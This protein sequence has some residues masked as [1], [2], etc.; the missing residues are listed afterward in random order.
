M[1][2]RIPKFGKLFFLASLTIICLKT[3][4]K[5]TILSAFR[6][7]SWISFNS[8]IVLQKIRPTNGQISPSQPVTLLPT[9]NSFRGICNRTPQRYE[10]VVVQA[11]TLLN[12]IQQDKRLVHRKFQ[13]Y[14][15]HFIRGLLTSAFNHYHLDRDLNAIYKEKAARTAQKTIPRLAAQKRR[16][17]TLLEIRG[18]T[19]KQ[20]ENNVEKTRNALRQTEI[21][22]EKKAKAKINIRK[23]TKKA[24]FKDV[25]V[26]LKARSWLA[27]SLE[28]VG[29]FVN[30]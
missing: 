30:R 21:A 29:F 2:N 14:L 3:F 22:V 6:K 1:W 20:A 25:K 26:Y 28:V 15:E 19:I 10:Q 23:K 4:K 9:A 12:T 13:S 27:T 5:S 7:T 24:W 16:V 11:R 18:R 8:E 17:I